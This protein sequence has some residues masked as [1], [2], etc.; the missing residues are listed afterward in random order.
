VYD[1]ID[2]STCGVKSNAEL[3]IVVLLFILFLTLA[4]VLLLVVVRRRR[5]KRKMA[6]IK[7]TTNGGNAPTSMA[8]RQMRDMSPF[9]I[10]DEDEEKS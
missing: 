10:N 9:S 2:P 3:V 8:Y 7:S 1:V 5:M 4:V 6:S